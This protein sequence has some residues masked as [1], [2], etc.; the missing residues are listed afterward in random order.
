M[1]MQKPTIL[2]IT[3][4]ITLSSVTSFA[5]AELSKNTPT[6]N[7]TLITLLLSSYYGETNFEAIS[8][9]LVK[10][11]PEAPATSLNPTPETPASV[12]PQKSSTEPV[13]LEPPFQQAQ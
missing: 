3:L 6:K 9:A 10:K 1:K 4:M 8:E 13:S 5:S 12:E 11:T 2:W 7:Q